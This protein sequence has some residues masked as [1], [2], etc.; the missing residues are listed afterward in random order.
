[1]VMATMVMRYISNVSKKGVY[2]M[3]TIIMS[4]SIIR[5]DDLSGCFVIENWCG[6][7]TYDASHSI[8]KNKKLLKGP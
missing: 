3:A 6:C 7:L 5:T 8:K 4:F 1:M 2:T